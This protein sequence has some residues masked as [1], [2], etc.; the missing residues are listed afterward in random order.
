MI[1]KDCIIV[2][3]KIQGKLI[4]TNLSALFA[5]IRSSSKTGVLKLKYPDSRYNTNYT[6]FKGMAGQVQT[7]FAAKI[8]AIMKDYGVPKAVIEHLRAQNRSNTHSKLM[9]TLNDGNQF[10]S[11]DL[12]AKAFK[13]RMLMSLVPIWHR[14]DGN[15][16]LDLSKPVTLTTK[17]GVDLDSISLEVSKRLDELTRDH[18]DITCLGPD[19]VFV[20]REDQV[21]LPIHVRTFGAYELRVLSALA[22]PATLLETVIE[23]RLSWDELLTTIATLQA[24]DIIKH[25]LP[26]TR[27]KPS[28][29]KK[30]QKARVDEFTTI[31][32]ESAEGSTI[33]SAKKGINLKNLKAA[34]KNLLR[35]PFN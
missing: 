27:V 28:S 26:H 15:F 7:L 24:K 31:F 18:K 3:S 9:I 10:L 2:E 23:S 16:E 32:D 22:E 33:V 6:L 20:A 12:I 30:G 17:K 5:S 35:S 8:S 13:R 14:D 4:G 34:I 29:K 21:G 1:T 11:S 19:D 25:V